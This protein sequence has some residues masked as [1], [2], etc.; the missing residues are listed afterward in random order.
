MTKDEIV[1]ELM[2]IKTR[3]PNPHIVR[4]TMPIIQAYVYD[5]IA[6][7]ILARETA[8]WDRAKELDGYNVGYKHGYDDAMRHTGHN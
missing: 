3:H 2:N 6:D 1:K 7:F 8:I 4:T 5:A